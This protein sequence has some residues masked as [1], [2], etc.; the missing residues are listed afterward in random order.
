M[1]LDVEAGNRSASRAVEGSLTVERD[2]DGR[3]TALAVGGEAERAKKLVVLGQIANL[4]IDVERGKWIAK[5]DAEDAIGG[6]GGGERVGRKA[7]EQDGFRFAVVVSDHLAADWDVL[8]VTLAN[9]DE[10]QVG[11]D[12]DG[13]GDVD[14]R[15]AP[16]DVDRAGN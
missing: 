2:G 1:T 15:A 13:V 8:R 10:F 7:L 3:G 12:E 9:G 5:V 16:L 14:D 11:I 6:E 4:Q